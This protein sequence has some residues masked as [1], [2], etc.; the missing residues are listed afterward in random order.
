MRKIG[1]ITAVVVSIGLAVWYLL[2]PS[3]PMDA[4]ETFTHRFVGLG[5]TSRDNKH[6][7]HVHSVFV[8]GDDVHA[9]RVYSHGIFTRGTRQINQGGFQKLNIR[10]I[11]LN[12]TKAEFQN[13]PRVDKKR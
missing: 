10:Y 7:G 13:L 5:V 8:K 9:I 3:V 4:K 6:V 2:L 12:V 1:T 11:T